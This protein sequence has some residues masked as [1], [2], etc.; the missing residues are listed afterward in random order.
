MTK[1][2]IVAFLIGFLSLSSFETNAQATRKTQT[3]LLQYCNNAQVNAEEIAEA[4]ELIVK[5]AGT[6]SLLEIIE[7]KVEVLFRDDV[8]ANVVVG[9]NIPEN[10]H[11]LFSKLDAGSEIRFKN[12]KSK[13]KE[14]AI[15]TAPNLTLKVY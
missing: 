7:F 2:F 13:T 11:R 3:C 4:K 15:V 8:I 1:H 6:S 14:G 12:V 9:E 10:I 5:T